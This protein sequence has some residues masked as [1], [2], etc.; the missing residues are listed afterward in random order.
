MADV[1]G[2]WRSATERCRGVLAYRGTIRMAGRFRLHATLGLAVDAAGHIGLRAV[3]LGPVFALGGDLTSATLFLNGD[4]RVVV[5]PPAEIIE[6]V[7]GLRL[8]PQRLLA[9]LSGCVSTSAEAQGAVRRGRIVEVSTRDAVVFL[10]ADGAGLRPRAGRF[11]GLTVEY[12]RFDASHYPRQLAIASAP[13]RSPE[14]NVTLD[15]R[16][17]DINP[18]FDGREFVVIPPA[19]AVPASLEDL[20]AAGPLGQSR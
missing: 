17:L 20:R 9:L 11:D 19:T 6:A 8:D 1:A 12:R 15:V 7:V 14:I 2:L 16:D 10:D 4:N 5:A 18:S 3:A 13:G